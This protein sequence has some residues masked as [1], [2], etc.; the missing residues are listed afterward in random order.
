M[1]QSLGIR[2][3]VA[4][5]PPLPTSVNCFVGSLSHIFVLW[6]GLPVWQRRCLMMSRSD[7][8]LDLKGLWILMWKYWS[9]CSWIYS[10]SHCTAALSWEPSNRS[11]K[12]TNRHFIIQAE[13]AVGVSRQHSADPLAVL[14]NIRRKIWN[15]TRGRCWVIKTFFCCCSF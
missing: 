4:P 14:K 8:Q 3:Q 13:F 12:K 1:C 11:E 5:L 15:E 7:F 6:P 2:Q 9:Y 10:T